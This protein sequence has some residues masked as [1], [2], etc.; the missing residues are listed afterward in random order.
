[1][2]KN[3]VQAPSLY[4]AGSGTIIGA[5]SI[6]LEELKDI[7]GNAITSITPFGDK[8]YITLEP[9]TSNEEA[10]TFT[11]VTVNANG[12]VTLTGIKTILAQTPYTETSGLVRSHAGSSLVVV[13]D[14]VAF[15]N[16]F[17]NK[18]NDNTFTGNN[19]FSNKV[20]VGAVTSS[21]L[22]YAATV[23][24]ANNLV[25]AGAADASTTT[26]GLNRMSAS[27]DVVVGTCTI[28]IASPAVFTINSHGLT[29]NDSITLATT[30][31]LPTGLSVGVTYYVSATGLTAN[32][33][34]V[35]A[36]LGG[37]SVNTSGSQSGTHTLTKTT[38]VAVASLDPRVPT[39]SEND[40]L[41]NLLAGT[42]FYGASSAGTDAYAITLSPAPAAYTNGMPIRFK[43]D[44]ANTGACTLNVNGLG[45][46]TIK[47]NLSVDLASGDIQA[48]QIVEVVYNSTGAAFE[49]TSNPATSNANSDFFTAGETI[50]AGDPL[51]VTKYPTSAASYDT[52]TSFYTASSAS[53][54]NSFTVA[55]NSNRILLV[56]VAC[57]STQSVSGVTYNG[58]AMTAL[59]SNTYNDGSTNYSLYYLL[60]PTTGANTL[61]VNLT[62][63]TG[64]GLNVYSYYNMEQQAPEASM[65][66]S[67]TNGGAITGNI[68][69][70]TNRALLFSGIGLRQAATVGG[71]A[72][73]THITTN[74]FG[75]KSADNMEVTP[76]ADKTVTATADGSGFGTYIFSYSLAVISSGATARVYKTSASQTQTCSSFVGFAD[77]SGTAGNPVSVNVAG[78]NDNQTSLNIGSVY[79]LS[80]T[81]GTLSTS[82]GTVSK[83]VG[84][85]ASTSK[86]VIANT[87]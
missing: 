78:V 34:Q 59:F 76:I 8:G 28:T 38:P 2:A 45:A 41:G 54:S 51:Y 23:D 43:A 33:F 14:N 65:N 47:K 17:A 42:F 27:S 80:N 15:W 6:T 74:T 63:A 30:G 87:L 60:A 16:T 68:V 4:L 5:T 82:A 64:V 86:I 32:T 57:N 36:T 48:N 40:M 66:T 75:F 29:Q 69:P 1:M 31:A 62:G 58:V 71:T 56:H 10:A 22:G 83:K 55:N 85:A 35:S 52:S 21:D 39:Q 67:G 24:Y 53:F 18:T 79:Y 46:I 37:A 12:T 20:A 73:S 26:K 11:G 84:V 44:V 50:A 13:T 25:A 9:D 49:M 77:E 7:Y 19:T 61:T 81:S 3:Y 72:W 70:I